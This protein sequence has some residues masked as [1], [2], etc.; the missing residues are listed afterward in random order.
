MHFTYTPPDKSS[1]Y[2]G[3]LIKRTSEIEEVLKET[4]PQ[5][6]HN[7]KYQFFIILTQSCDLVRRNNNSCKS[8]YIT[9]AVLYPLSLVVQREIAH[10]QYDPIERKLGFVNA[11]VKPK[12]HQFIERLFNNNESEYFFLYREP[13]YDLEEDYCAF[14]QQSITV[15]T[16]LWYDKL[17]RAKFLQLTESFQHKL[18]YIIGSL[19][20]RIGTEDWLPGQCTPEKFQQY[21]Q[22]PLEAP[23]LVLWIEDSTHKKVI[24]ALKR[25]N[26][27]ELT[28]KLL[29]EE[30]KK[31]RETK[32]KRKEEVLDII[33]SVLL[34]SEVNEEKIPKLLLRLENHPQFSGLIK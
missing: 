23:K 22:E 11:R 18:G 24:K 10:Y 30:V 9:L 6:F 4:H 28:Y 13:H 5:Y 19:Y 33:H 29:E 14:L 27:E 7:K 2:Q 12:I 15:E 3:D 26:E 1:L 25:Y 16:E 21:I 8:E 20:S 31:H 17:L 34:E 32:A